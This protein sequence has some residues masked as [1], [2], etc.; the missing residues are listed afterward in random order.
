MHLH[1]K[2]RYVTLKEE[3]TFVRAVNLNV[4]RNTH[5]NSLA[6]WI[7]RETLIKKEHDTI[8]HKC[9]DNSLA[10]HKFEQNQNLKAT[11]RTAV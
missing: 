7:G 4:Y 9:N 11:L 5:D 3:G 6:C 1:K 8:K 2:V 10:R